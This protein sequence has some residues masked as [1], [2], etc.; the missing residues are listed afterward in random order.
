M[1][2]VPIFTPIVIIHHLSDKINPKFA[3]ALFHVFLIHEHI[4]TM[5]I[6]VLPFQCFKTI[7]LVL[8]NNNKMCSRAAWTINFTFQIRQTA[9]FFNVYNAK[10]DSQ[11]II[12]ND[13]CLEYI[14]FRC[15]SL[16]ILCAA[17]GNWAQ[18]IPSNRSDFMFEN[19]ERFSKPFLINALQ[20]SLFYAYLWI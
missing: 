11:H 2:C 12:R 20:L 13:L 18:G 3:C 16:N 1:K 6:I 14:F 5:F 19:D 4:S 15:F 9:L 17:G 10:L 8:E 7:S